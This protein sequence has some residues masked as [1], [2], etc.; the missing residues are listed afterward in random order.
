MNPFENYLLTGQPLSERSLAHYRACLHGWQHWLAGQGWL[1]EEIGY[2]HLLFWVKDYRDQGRSPAYINAH[3]RAIRHYFDYL[4]SEQRLDYN[5][6]ASL[7]IRGVARPIPHG[8]LERDV[9]DELYQGYP[10]G[11]EKQLRN[12]VMLGLLVYQALTMGDLLPLTAAHLPLSE[13][14]VK[15]PASV[16]NEARTLKLEAGQMIP[17]HTYLSG[18][19]PGQLLFTDAGSIRQLSNRLG[20]LMGELRLINA[21]VRNA[22]QLRQSVITEWLKIKDIRYVQ[23]WAGHRYVSSTQR[24]QTSQLVSLQ[25]DLNRFHPLGE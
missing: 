15:V 25:A 14:V 13:G 22:S 4:I 18:L 1:L 24:Y 16:R 5:P 17:L 7:S 10:I 23:Q 11:E 12:K 6:A 2:E 3:L 21:Q 20:W 8:L 9:L 19:A